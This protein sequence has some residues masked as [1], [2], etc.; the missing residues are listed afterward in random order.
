MD[1]G[2]DNTPVKLARKIP[3]F[4]IYGTAYQRDGQL[5]F[6]NDLYHRDDALV[7]AV[8]DGAMPSQRAVQAI[9][10]LKRIATG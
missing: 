2:P 9:E 6:G 3:V 7:K 10:A 5:Y 1:Q 4:I 8:A